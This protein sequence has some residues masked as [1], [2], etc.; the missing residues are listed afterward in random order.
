MYQK[1]VVSI[2]HTSP[3]LSLSQT[4]THTHILP[5]YFLQFFLS[6]TASPLQLQVLLLSIWQ[7]TLDVLIAA[8]VH[9][10][11]SVAVPHHSHSERRLLGTV[12]FI[13]VVGGATRSVRRS[14]S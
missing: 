14:R 6:R 1:N 8:P 12:S 5:L 10:H 11:W 4:H 13:V 7:R 9:P 3:P 2:L